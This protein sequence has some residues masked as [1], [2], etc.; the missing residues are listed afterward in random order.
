MKYTQDHLEEVSKEFHNILFARPEGETGRE[1]LVNRNI[2]S[3]ENL[4]QYEIGYCPYNFPYPSSQTLWVDNRLWWMRGRLIVTIRG[5]HNRIISFAGRMIEKNKELLY[6]DLLTQIDNP[7]LFHLKGD[8]NKLK[9]LVDDWSSRKWINEVYSK[10]D[11]LF[12]LNV[13]KKHIFNMGYAIIVEGYMD[14]ISLWMNGFPNTVAVCGV[15]MSEMHLSLLKRYTNYFIYCLDGD[16]SGEKAMVKI[17]D[18]I[19]KK[20]DE[21]LGYYIIY[22]PKVEEKWLDPEDALI[23][24]EYKDL[25]INALIKASQREDVKIKTRFLDLSDNITKQI[26]KKEK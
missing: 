20:Y 13:A 26:L 23:H 25:F 24:T 12:G 4:S 3:L 16:N 9:E 8:I 14:A 22:L 6:N 11:Y 10:K 2:G 15:A 7:I 5:Q 18:L 1:F 19:N 21:Y 17:T